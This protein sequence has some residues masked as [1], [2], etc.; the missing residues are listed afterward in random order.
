MTPFAPSCPFHERLCSGAAKLSFR[1]EGK[2][3]L[4]PGTFNCVGRVHVWDVRLLLSWNY[5]FREYCCCDYRRAIHVVCDLADNRET[6]RTV[7]RDFQ[8]GQM[9]WGEVQPPLVSVL[10][11]LPRTLAWHGRVWL[12]FT[13]AM[14]GGN[15]LLCAV[16]LF[17]RLSQ[18]VALGRSEGSTS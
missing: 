1:V 11:F 4:V 3:Y 12:F 5:W 2:P 17:G 13:K 8:G 9:R 15:V 14:N 18:S 16:N 6:W 10:C 7:L